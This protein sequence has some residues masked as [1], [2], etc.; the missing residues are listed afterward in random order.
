MTTKCFCDNCG[1][2]GAGRAKVD[3]A[4]SE[5]LKMSGPMK[6]DADLC[7]K[8]FDALL[9]TLLPVLKSETERQM[10]NQ[11]GSAPINISPF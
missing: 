2:E 8:C 6:L 7:Q 3:V 5:P 9:R 1:A 11:H 4:R 10:M